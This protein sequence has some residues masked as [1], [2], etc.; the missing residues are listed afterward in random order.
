[1]ADASNVVQLPPK[2]VGQA[3]DKKVLEE[4]WTKGVLDPGFVVIPS[5]LLR[6]QKRLHIDSVELAVL[7]HLI[8]HWWDNDDMPFPSKKRLGERIG[9]S[10]KTV[11]RAIKKLEDEKLIKRVKRHNKSG[12]Q[13]SNI[14]DL[15][16]LIERLK[17]IAKELVEAR[18]EAKETRRSPEKPGHAMCKAAK[19][20][21]ASV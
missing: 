7:L 6:A 13:T 10:D 11:Q 19:K 9:V 20:K 16:P 2:G 8:D 21:A 4:R 14:Y 1:M 12:G 5:V 17:P 15:T 18:E 3:T